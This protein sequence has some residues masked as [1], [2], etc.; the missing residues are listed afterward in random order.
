VWLSLAQSQTTEGSK[1][2]YAQQI[3]HLN[4]HS[5]SCRSEQDALQLFLLR[6]LHSER[7][8]R[9]LLFPRIKIS[10][11]LP[12]EMP[13]HLMLSLYI[14]SS[15]E[16]KEE[17]AGVSPFKC[18]A[19]LAPALCIFGLLSVV[20]SSISHGPQLGF[21]D[22]LMWDMRIHLSKGNGITHTHTH[23]HNFTYFLKTR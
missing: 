20:F 22:K 12:Q 2:S 17:S 1:H 6:C 13:L 5:L 7:A 11:P 18:P 3:A 15:L 9:F 19:Y 21:C 8:V 14:I 4:W 10:C 23:T 16:V